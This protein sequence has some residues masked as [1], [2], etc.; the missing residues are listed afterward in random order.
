MTTHLDHD[1]VDVEPLFRPLDVAEC[2]LENRIVMSPMTREHA[3]DGVLRPGVDEYY[4]RRARNGVGLVVTEGTSIDHPVS[5][6]SRNVPN[7]Y[8]DAA[9]ARWRLV[10]DRVHAAGSRIFPQLW[11]TGVARRRKLTFNP[12]TPSMSPSGVGMDRLGPDHAQS[13]VA[14][15][16][17]TVPPCAMTIPDIEAVIEAF[18]NAAA[19]AKRIGFDGIAIHGAHGYL[20]DQFMWARSNHRTDEYGGSLEKRLRFSVELVRE[21]RRRVGAGYPIM[22][23]FSQWKGW[24]YEARLADSPQELERILQPLSSAGVDI[25]DASTRR[26]WLPEFEGST[27]NLAGWAKKLTGSTT[28]TVGSV[29]ADD[30]SA[31]TSTD[32][33]VSAIARNLYRLM[34]MFSRGDFDLVGIGRALIANPDWPILV[35]NHR[36]ERLRAFHADKLDGLEM[37]T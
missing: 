7:I 20:P 10:I 19:D 15:Q 3:I 21:V 13:A 22:F 25:F 26:F 11:H 36:L 23:R 18:G 37:R 31:G 17:S 4:E 34:N 30:A 9:L 35:R 27:M 28:M 12:A 8:G 1:M 16:P 2:R 32:A 24:D 6:Y 33:G 14:R 5:H 29:G